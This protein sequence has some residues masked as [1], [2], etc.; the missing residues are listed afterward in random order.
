M[1]SDTPMA[2]RMSCSMSRTARPNRSRT[3][4]I[5]AMSSVFSAAFMPAAGSSRHS[6]LGPVA[7]A[8]AISSRRCSP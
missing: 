6:T 4:R 5:S 3:E 1:R 2:T 8:R 7:S